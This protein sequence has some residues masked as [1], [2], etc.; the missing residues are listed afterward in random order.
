V[1]AYPTLLPATVDAVPENLAR[2]MRLSK[3]LPAA[4]WDR[5]RAAAY[6]RANY[7]CPHKAD[8]SVGHVVGLVPRVLPAAQCATAARL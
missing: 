4:D 8:W 3:A 7:R 5:L 1:A 2:S 6:Q